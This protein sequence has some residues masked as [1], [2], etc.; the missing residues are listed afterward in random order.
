MN[1]TLDKPEQ[2][3]HNI[4]LGYNCIHLSLC[5]VLNVTLDEPEHRLSATEVA[6]LCTH[7]YNWRALAQELGIQS[8]VVETIAK[9]CRSSRECCWQVLQISQPS[10]STLVDTLKR[11]GYFMLPVLLE[12]G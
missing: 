5:A 10:R 3:L 7:V 1:I 11:L 6:T 2:I 8:T 9:K 4:Q 12:I